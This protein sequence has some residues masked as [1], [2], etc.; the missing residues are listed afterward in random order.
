LPPPWHAAG[1]GASATGLAV[2][3]FLALLLWH[4]FPPDVH[5][6]ELEMTAID[7]GQ[8]DSIFVAFPMENACSSMAAAFPPSATRPGRSS[9]SAKTWWRPTCGTAAS[10]SW[11][12]WRS[13]TAT[14]TTSAAS[15]RW[16]PIF[17]PR[18]CGPALSPTAPP[19]GRCNRRPPPTA[20]KSFPCISP[21]R[22]A[23]GG[24][25]IEVLAPPPDYVPTDSAKNDDSLVLRVGYGR[26]G[27]LLTGDAE[28]P[29]EREMLAEA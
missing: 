26:N 16:L 6:G 4:P 21:R 15:P 3:V 25:E 8:G 11:M 14:K 24:A 19:G 13:R 5:P 27:F 9:I 2:A 23:F 10:A 22:F 17:T 29:I 28:R 12:W 1:G 18:S 20:S 7:V